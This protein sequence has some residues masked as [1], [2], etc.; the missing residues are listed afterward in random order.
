MLLGMWNKHSRQGCSMH[1]APTASPGPGR[2][3]RE[4]LGCQRQLPM[5]RRQVCYVTKGCLQPLVERLWTANTSR[6][7]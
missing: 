2:E 3:W 5:N 4:C 7:H 6:S 1:L